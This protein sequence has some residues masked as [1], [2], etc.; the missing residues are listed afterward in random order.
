MAIYRLLSRFADDSHNF[1]MTSSDHERDSTEL[2]FTSAE[3]SP[4]E[5]ENGFIQDAERG[6]CLSFELRKK[7]FSG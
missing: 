1:S 6:M 3:V 7:Y 2:N 5:E 4:L